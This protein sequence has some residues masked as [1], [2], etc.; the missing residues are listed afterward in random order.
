M[1]KTFIGITMD[2]HEFYRNASTSFL[3][4]INS[5]DYSYLYTI[6][7]SSFFLSSSRGNEGNDSLMIFSF[8]SF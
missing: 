8:S 3:K 6:S 2:M 7:Y 5:P 4:S 1:P